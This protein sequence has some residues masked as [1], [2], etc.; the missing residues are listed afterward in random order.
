[1]PSDIGNLIDILQT[2]ALLEQQNAINKQLDELNA[3]N[4]RVKNLEHEMRM[5]T[6]PYY[7]EEYIQQRMK[8]YGSKIQ[9]EYDRYIKIYEDELKT[10]TEKADKEYNER[11]KKLDEREKNEANKIK[12]GELFS[13]KR[14]K[15]NIFV[16]AANL[17]VFFGLLASLFIFN[18][19][20]QGAVDYYTPIIE[21]L[22]YEIDIRS[23]EIGSLQTENSNLNN[24]YQLLNTRYNN[25][26]ENYILLSGIQEQSDNAVKDANREVMRYDQENVFLERKVSELEG[27]I[28]SLNDE[29]TA[30]NN[31]I[32]KLTN[33]HNKEIQQ[34]TSSNATSSTEY[35]TVVNRARKIVEL[36]GLPFN[37]DLFFTNNSISVIVYDN[38]NGTQKLM[39]LTTIQYTNN[40]PIVHRI[41]NLNPN[42]QRWTSQRLDPNLNTLTTTLFSNPSTVYSADYNVY[43]LTESKIRSF[44]KGVDGSSLV[45]NTLDRNRISHTVIG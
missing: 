38:T 7:R 3:T 21:Q 44:Y 19:D 4:E 14:T 37:D 2:G 10:R 27:E 1:M 5:S 13:Q 25:L 9:R 28:V 43:G 40:N 17:I 34:L 33:N 12:I 31:D 30:L 45:Y 22:N 20:Y 23:T 32:T 26:E 35:L 24:D 11:I 41:D 6:D 29:I 15:W 8:D 16:V 18:R 42:E 39:T 36:F